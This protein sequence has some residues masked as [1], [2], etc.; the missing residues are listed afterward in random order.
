[1]KK[2]LIFGALSLLACKEQKVSDK[3]VVAEEQKSFEMYEM[4]EMALLMEQMYVDHMRLKEKIVQGE[5]LGTF[6]EYLSK[7]HS[8]VMTDNTDRDAFFEEQSAL[9]EA[10]HKAI[11]E[12]TSENKKEAYNHAVQACISCHEVKCSGPIPKIK[13]LIIQ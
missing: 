12:A 7:I 5:E 2:Y 4:S 13:K 6:P 11:Y 8:S 3:E 10:A 1:M 9:F